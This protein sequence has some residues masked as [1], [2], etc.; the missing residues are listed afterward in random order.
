MNRYFTR[1]KAGEY[2]FKNAIKII[3]ADR[4]RWVVYSCSGVVIGTFATLKAAKYYL[5]HRYCI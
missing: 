3:K 5:Y 4:N 1:Y 2:G